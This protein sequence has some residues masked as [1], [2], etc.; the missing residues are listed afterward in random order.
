VQYIKIIRPFNFLFVLL[1]VIF[2]AYYQT[3]FIISLNPI[4]AAIS[5]SLI[6]SSGYVF[7]DIYDIEIDKI[8][9]PKRPLPS[10]RI[11]IPSAR[12]FAILLFTIGFLLVLYLQN[13]G[14]IILA[15]FNSIILW[16]YA[17]RGKQFFLV[18]NLMV[19]FASA[20]TF[21]YGGMVN[22]NLNN[23][24]FVFAA[25]LLYTLIRELIKDIEDMK[26]DSKQTAKTFPIVY[27]RNKTLILSIIFAILFN[28]VLLIGLTSNFYNLVLFLIILVF[29]GLF[30]IADLVFLYFKKEKQFVYFSEKAMKINML[31]FL[32]VLWVVQ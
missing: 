32:I 29:V 14:M 22:D 30:V 23:S 12:T 16:L 25:A 1:A 18:G 2:G 19:A 26:G 21:V 6:C 28:A 13:L 15:L 9:K 4:L 7:N 20:S 31:I 10:G 8:N 5:A 3:E 11:S 17:K 24:L 27:G